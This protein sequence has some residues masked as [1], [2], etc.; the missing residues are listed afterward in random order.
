MGGGQKIA[1]ACHSVTRLR[2]SR[3]LL[4]C[5]TEKTPCSSEARDSEAGRAQVFEV[6]II[7]SGGPVRENSEF[8]GNKGPAEVCG[9]SSTLFDP[10]RISEGASVGMTQAPLKQPQHMRKLLPK[11]IVSYIQLFLKG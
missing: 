4:P 9:H 8:P 2:G 1:L 11:Y 7:D 6:L 5:V 10:H 3:A